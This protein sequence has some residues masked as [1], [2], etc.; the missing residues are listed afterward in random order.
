M[1]CDSHT[2]FLEN[3]KQFLDTSD[4]CERQIMAIIEDTDFGSTNEG[5]IMFLIRGQKLQLFHEIHDEIK[6]LAL[7]GDQIKLQVVF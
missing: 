7:Y 2:N 1:V 3:Q 4:A 5:Q 6:T